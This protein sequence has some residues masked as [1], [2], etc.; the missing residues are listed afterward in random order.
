MNECE[1]GIEKTHLEDKSLASWDL[2]SNDKKGEPERRI[3]LSAHYT[4][5]VFLTSMTAA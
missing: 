1:D 2:Q 4:I 3:L 5:I